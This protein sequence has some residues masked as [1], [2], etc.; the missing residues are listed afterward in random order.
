MDMPITEIAVVVFAALMGGILLTRINQ[1]PIVGYILAGLILGPSGFK[2]VADSKSV[3]ELAEL[4]VLLLLF[5]VGMEL[6]LSSFRK[7]WKQTV[8][9]LIAQLTACFLLVQLGGSLFGWP[10][11][12][13]LFL[14]FAIALSSTAV[15]VNMLDTTKLMHTNTG[16]LTIG[17]LVAQDIAFIPMMLILRTVGGDAFEYMVIVKLVLSVV[18]LVGLIIYLSGREPLEL[19]HSAQLVKHPELIPLTALGFCFGLAAIMGLLKLSPAYGAFLAG[20]ILGNSSKRQKVIQ[21]T[22]PIQIVLMM[23]FFLSIGLLLD[24]QYIWAHLSKVLGLLFLVTIFKT[25]LNIGILRVMRQ[26]WSDAFLSGL[27]LSQVGE[28]T[29]LLASATLA[30]K[31]IDPQLY[32]LI[33]SVTALSLVMSPLWYTMIKRL[34]SISQR[35]ALNFR[36]V[37]GETLG[38]ELS[39]C[40]R[41]AHKIKEITHHKK[42]PH[43]DL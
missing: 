32:K 33:I 8:G 34:R 27:L 9:A 26:C 10:F 19:P 2:L 14:T 41:A 39:A 21:N 40:S 12:I 36:Q 35:N 15:A 24:L 17:I 29:F 5:L 37:V 30:H 43:A 20:L 31:I 28:F 22:H 42:D 11:P 18:V 16:K 25:L 23:V 4:G 38:T 1:P 7:F 3:H 6:D 13:V